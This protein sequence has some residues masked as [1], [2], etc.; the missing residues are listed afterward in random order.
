MITLRPATRADIAQL[1]GDEPLPWRVQAIAGEIDG[2]VIGV[3]GLVFRP[4]GVWATVLLTDEG[5]RHKLSLHRAARMTLAMAQRAGVHTLYAKAE[6]GR[7]GAE[8]WLERLGFT[9]CGPGDLFVWSAPRCGT[10]GI[11]RRA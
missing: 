3:G 8:M 1:Q 2:R 7:A 5:R 6:P 11:P 4:D 10:I 9:R